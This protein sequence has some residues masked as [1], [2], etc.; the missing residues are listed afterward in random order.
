MVVPFVV[1]LANVD[2]GNGRYQERRHR[3]ERV[4]LAKPFH[5]TSLIYVG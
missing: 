2:A 3:D 1:S 5:A 4:S